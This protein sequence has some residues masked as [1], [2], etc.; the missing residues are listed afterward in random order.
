MRALLPIAVVSFMGIAL[1]GCVAYDVAS[2][3]VSVATTVVSTTVS[4]AGSVAKGVAGTQM[5]HRM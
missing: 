2:A 1:S 5:L 4:A 3:G